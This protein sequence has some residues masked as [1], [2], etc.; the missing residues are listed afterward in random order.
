IGTA[1]LDIDTV[2]ITVNPVNDA[3]V[4]TVP[5]A[6]TVNEDTALV[7]STANGN[8]IA[9]SDVDDADN[10]ILGDE[11]LQVSLAATIGTL[12]LS[13]TSRLSSI[14]GAN[15]TPAMTFT[16][17]LTDLNTALGGLSYQA[18]LNFH[19]TATLTVTTNDL[20]NSGN[21]TALSDTDAVAITVNAVN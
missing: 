9:V 14:G 7:F 6:Q 5:A 18:P 4:N 12:T 8:R 17:T 13:S 1:L 2:A 15:G 19:G 20:G 16:G 21:G 11:N 10:A 3:P